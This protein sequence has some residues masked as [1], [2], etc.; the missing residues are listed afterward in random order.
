MSRET[1][2]DTFFAVSVLL[3][4]GLILSACQTTGST[5]VSAQNGRGSMTWNWNLE[6]HGGQDEKSR[7]TPTESAE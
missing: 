4:T 2:I 1:L 5:E 7:S 6:P 3:L